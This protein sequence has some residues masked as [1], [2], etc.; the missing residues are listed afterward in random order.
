L[1]KVRFSILAGY[2]VNKHLLTAP[3]QILRPLVLAVAL[4]AWTGSPVQA[5]DPGLV[6]QSA[7]QPRGGP[8]PQ[9]KNPGAR[10]TC[11]AAQAQYNQEQYIVALN[12]MRQ[13]IAAS[14]KE[15]VLRVMLGAVHMRRGAIVQAEQELR[16]ARTD[17]APHQ[18]VL[19]TL[20]TVMI[21]RREEITLLAEFAEPAADATGE[22]ACDLLQ[23]RALALESLGQYAE[24]AAAMDR[25]L[26]L[27]RDADGLLIRARLATQMKDAALARK[28]VD[29]AYRMAPKSGPVMVAKLEQLELSN[30]AAGVLALS[31]QMQKFYPKGD[32]RGARIRVF[33]KQN[34]DAKAKAEVDAILAAIPKA[35][36]G[37]LYKGVLMARAHDKMGAAQTIQGLPPDFV[38]Q[39]P[40][41]ALQMA[42]IVLDNGNVES[43]VWILG[44]ALGVA[45]DLLDVRLRLVA[46]KM[47][48]NSPQGAMLLLTPVQDLQDARVRKAL[49]VVRA[50]IAK[51]RAF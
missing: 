25:S 1:A 39:H 24:A 31:D 4:A 46:I 34:Q 37:L 40:E 19:P 2:V 12:L 16:Q 35:P 36:L 8:C 32:F 29:D 3:P 45:P 9:V 33:I 22:V 14:P 28:L 5:A 44:V 18:A 48:Q 10:A 51:N 50:Q 41:Y 47:S 15:G 42:Q 11:F 49:A 20:F 27:G 26:S 38:R 17:G 21:A 6:A 43:A 7:A 23:G 30:D 13:A